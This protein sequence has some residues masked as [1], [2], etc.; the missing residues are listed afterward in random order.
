MPSKPTDIVTKLLANSTNLDIVKELVADDATYVSLNY[1]NPDLQAVCPHPTYLPF[2]PNQRLT[3]HPPPPQIEPWCGTHPQAGP[4]AIYK[5]FV[6][7]AT[8]WE[9]LNFETYV[10][11]GD[12]TPLAP[13][14][15]TKEEANVAVFG[16]F[17]YRSRTLGKI[18]DS[19]FAV[20]AKVDVGREK[21]VYMQFM[22]DTL[23]TAASF[24]KSGRMVY[25]SHP[26]GGEVVVGD[27]E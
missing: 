23:S 14:G 21:V 16:R 24:R 3:L 9:V 7:V 2:H 26:K 17:K 22:E 10:A 4:A 18:T 8:Y 13:G 25:A 5:T 20:W 1:D 6:D 15:G 11:F 12:E 19:P 27:G